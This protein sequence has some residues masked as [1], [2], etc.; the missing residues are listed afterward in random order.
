MSTNLVDE[1]RRTIGA[2]HVLTAEADMAPHLNDWRRR[3]AGSALAVALPADTAEVAQVVRLCSQAGAPIVPQGGNTGLVGGATPDRSGRSI[4]LGTRRLNRVRA[5]DTDND[6]LTAEAG[7][8]L[9]ALQEAARARD[10]L[11]PLSLAAQGS[12][13]IGGNLSTNAGG[14]QVLRYGNARDLALGLEVVLPGG[15][16]WYGLRGLR[17]DNTGYDL[18]HLFI[19]AEGT[20]GVIT[21]ATLKLFPLPRAQLTALAAVPDLAA[22]VGLLNRMRA[23]AGPGLTAFEL[24]SAAGLQ[25]LARHFPDMRQPLPLDQPWFALIELSDHES[26][27]HAATRLEAGLEGAAQEGQIADAAIGRSLADSAAIWRLRETLPEAQA[28]SGGNVKHDVS[29]PISAIVRFV[30]ETDAALLSRFDWL[31]PITFGHLGDGNLHY[32]IATRDGVPIE[33]AFEHQAAISEIVHDMVHRCGGSISAE[34]GLGQLK[35][36]TI[37]RYKSPLEMQMMR[38]VKRA[39]DP[40]GLMNPGK[41]L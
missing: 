17:K 41:V 21:A 3:Y 10:R 20:L 7:C 12:C 36:E 31:Q 29:L 35:R 8:V 2:R 30:A 23:A 28:R 40:S 39:L 15:E 37:T 22:A 19:G 32:N 5:I 24:M 25:L 6:T 13:T 26:E 16:I 27:Q 4:V 9:Q 1:L 18:K 33:R 14:T 34:H 11:F 38:S